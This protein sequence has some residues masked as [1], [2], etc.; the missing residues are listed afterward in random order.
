M[1]GVHDEDGLLILTLRRPDKANAL[2]KAMLEDLD[3]AL[4]KTCLLYTSRCV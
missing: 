3:A 1:I 4:T 2:T